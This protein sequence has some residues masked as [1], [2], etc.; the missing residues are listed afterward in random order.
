MVVV[1]LE[2]LADS[3]GG[4]L[5]EQ[6]AFVGVGV[7]AARLVRTSA[8]THTAAG[9]KAAVEVGEAIASVQSKTIVVGRWSTERLGASGEASSGLFGKGARGGGGSAAINQVVVLLPLGTKIRGDVFFG[10]GGFFSPKDKKKKETYRCG[11]KVRLLVVDRLDHVVVVAP[12][13]GGHLMAALKVVLVASLAAGH[14]SVGLRS[15]IIV[16]HE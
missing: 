12:V 9:A 14:A 4:G 2:V 7:G 5:A 16:H 13:R 3:V 15:G 11:V 1:V 10:G 8:I 6:V